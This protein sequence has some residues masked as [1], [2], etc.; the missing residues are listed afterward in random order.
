MASKRT[1]DRQKRRDRAEAYEKTQ[2]D[3]NWFHGLD[4]EIHYSLMESPHPKIS[5]FAW[6]QP[7]IPHSLHTYCCWLVRHGYRDRVEAIIYG[8]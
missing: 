3:L 8:N 7:D 1:I 5:G 4:K 6:G 2:A